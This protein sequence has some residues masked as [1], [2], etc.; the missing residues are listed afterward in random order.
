MLAS[1]S[2]S[3]GDVKRSV[4][5]M[6]MSVISHAPLGTKGAPF[7][8]LPGR[9][10]RFMVIEYAKQDGNIT[11]SPQGSADILSNSTRSAIGIAT[12]VRMGVPLLRFYEKVSPQDGDKHILDNNQTNAKVESICA[13]LFDHLSSVSDRIRSPRHI[14]YSPTKA[15]VFDGPTRSENHVR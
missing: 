5:D 12:G 7:F 8:Q 3:P 13:E 9:R 11:R 6:G 15:S 2:R 1:G 10:S 4:A 14:D